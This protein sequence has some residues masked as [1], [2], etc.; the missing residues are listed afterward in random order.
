MRICKLYGLP[1]CHSGLE[2]VR[3][4]ISDEG[5]SLIKRYEGY[6]TTPYRCPAGLY[7]VGYGHVIGNG[8]QL[9]DEWNRT[10]S[11]GEIDE[12]LRTDLARFERGV[13]RYCTVYITQSQFDSLVSFSFNLG[14]GVLQRS[15]LRQ[16]LNRGDYDGASK[17]FLKYTRAGG[18]VLKG[19]VRRR[20]AEYNLFNRHS[21]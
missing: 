9:P 14:L 15:T 20:Q 5:I 1:S 6:K 4:T 8:L 19:L 10:F 21:P 17:E 16:K 11:L 2:V 18:K 3:L 12:L 13:L 7:T